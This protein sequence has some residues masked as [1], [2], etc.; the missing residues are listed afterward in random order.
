VG[1]KGRFFSAATPKPD[2]VERQTFG[3][4]SFHCIWVDD[5]TLALGRNVGSGNWES[6]RTGRETKVIVKEKCK[7]LSR[8]Q[9]T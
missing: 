1:R 4:G 5:A 3:S 2:F 9:K 8:C 6:N 7:E